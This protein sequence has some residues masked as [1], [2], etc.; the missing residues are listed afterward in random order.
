LNISSVSFG[1]SESYS[2]SDSSS[3]ITQL[4]KQKTSIQKEIEKANQS[5][6]DAE[7]KQ[8]KIQMLYQQIQQIEMQI[9]QIRSQQSQKAAN[10]VKA[11]EMSSSGEKRTKEQ[12]GLVNE[13]GKNK[14]GEKV[15]EEEDSGL[16][17]QA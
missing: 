17:I 15:D 5:D 3:Q 1:S 4:E 10:Q 12:S 8:Q 7:T 11:N 2:S 14:T 6:G 13:E 9:Q 16:D